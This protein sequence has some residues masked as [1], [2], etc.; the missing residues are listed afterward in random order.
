MR[1]DTLYRNF[2]CHVFPEVTPLLELRYPHSRETVTG[3]HK[4][5]YYLQG[6]NACHVFR[7]E[8]K[9]IR[10]ASDEK[11]RESAYVNMSCVS[12]PSTV[13]Q[14]RNF[15]SPY[16]CNPGSAKDPPSAPG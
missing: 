13:T 3:D 4:F 14:H 8:L 1:N 10:V 7:G 5:L 12:Q 6:W 16:P 9:G 2:R 15:L 11:G